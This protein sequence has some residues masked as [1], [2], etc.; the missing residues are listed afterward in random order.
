MD[1]ETQMDAETQEAAEM[2]LWRLERVDEEMHEQYRRLQN[3]A[4]HCERLMERRRGQVDGRNDPVALAQWLRAG[5]TRQPRAH[6]V[7]ALMEWELPRYID[8]LQR[9]REAYLTPPPPITV[10]DDILA[11]GEDAP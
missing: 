9:L 1:E 11:E 6:A 7:R 10:F 2:L 8:W 5:G 3:I 4:G